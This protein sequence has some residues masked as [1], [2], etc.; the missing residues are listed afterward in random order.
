M[1]T[2]LP[3]LADTTN[4]ALIT[5][6]IANPAACCMTLCGMTLSMPLLCESTKLLTIVYQLPVLC[7]S[8]A[9]TRCSLGSARRRR[10]I[11]YS[12]CKAHDLPRPA[13]LLSAISRSHELYEHR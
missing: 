10:Y 12:M 4:P 11:K 9:Q 6:K 7:V 2:P 3:A 1:T 8:L 13:L 5:V